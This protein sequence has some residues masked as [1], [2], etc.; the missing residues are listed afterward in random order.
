MSQVTHE[1][2]A[3]ADRVWEVLAD[4]WTYAAWVVGASHIRDVD[5]TWPAAGSRL[6][7]SVGP[8]PL[9]IKDHTEVL[10]GQPPTRLELRARTWPLGEATV[11]FEIEPLGAGKCRVTIIETPTRGPAAVAHNPVF[12]ALLDA[13]NRETLRRLADYAGRGAVRDDGAGDGGSQGNPAPI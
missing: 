2:P 4:G 3:P 10:A 11:V 7:H 9:L 1:I 13:R 6:H 12:D 8:W 5:E